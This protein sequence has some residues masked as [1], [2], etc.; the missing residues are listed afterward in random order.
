LQAQ[1]DLGLHV[2]QLHLDQWVGG[3]A[4]F[5]IAEQSIFQ[6]DVYHHAMEVNCGHRSDNRLTSYLPSPD[7]GIAC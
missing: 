7:H 1:R 3:W 5:Y 6:F 4:I 2:G